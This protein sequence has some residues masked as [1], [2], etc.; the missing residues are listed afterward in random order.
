[1]EMQDRRCLLLKKNVPIKM[2][3][4]DKILHHIN[5]C[6]YYTTDYFP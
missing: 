1:M 4:H 3:L 5:N 2:C 6:F